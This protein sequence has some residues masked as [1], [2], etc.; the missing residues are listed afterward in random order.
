[1]SQKWTLASNTTAGD[2]LTGI[3]NA[4][5]HLSTG[6]LVQL[7]YDPS[8][9][10]PNKYSLQLVPGTAHTTPQTIATLNA[11]PIA[12]GGPTFATGQQL[13]ICRDAS[14]NLYVIGIVANSSLPNYLAGN[15]S[16]QAFTKG[17]G[18]T[19]SAQTAV[20][21]LNIPQG[22][23]TLSQYQ[24]ATGSGLN[25]VWVNTGGGTNGAGHLMVMGNSGNGFTGWLYT[26][27]AGQMLLG[28]YTTNVGSG[29]VSG[30]GSNPPPTF[31]PNCQDVVASSFGATTGL[32]IGQVGSAANNAVVTAWSVNSSGVI[33]TTVITASVPTGTLSASTKFSV[34]LLQSNRY[35]VVF[36]S[37]SN[38][39]QMTVINYSG[40]A[41]LSVSGVDTGTTSNFPAPSATL[42]W[43]CSVG[44]DGTLYVFGWSSATATTMLR[45]PF[46]F[47]G[48]VI[49]KGSVVTDDTAIGSG[50]TN[51]TIRLVN[52]PIDSTHVDYQTTNTNGST[53]GLLG[54]FSTLPGPTN[55]PVLL[56]P[57]NN[58]VENLNAGYM[59]TWQ[60]S[61]PAFGDAQTA[62]AFKRQASGGTVQW[63]TGAAWTTAETFISSV[64]SSVTFAAA[65]WTAATTYTWAVAT[66]GSA[67]IAGPYAGWWTIYS[68]NAAPST[69]TISASYDTS[70]NRVTLTI[71]G[72]GTDVAEVQVSRDGGVTWA[73]LRNY[74]ALALAAGAGTAYDYEAV[75][76]SV[77]TYRVRQYN[78]SQAPYDT[79]SAWSTSAT[80]TPALTPNFWLRN[81]ADGSIGMAVK[82]KEGT[83][84]TQLTENLT[85][86]Y[87]L[88]SSYPVVLADT[89]KGEDGQATM[90]TQGTTEETNLKALMSQQN[91]LLLQS[92]D[93]RQWYIR[94]SVSRARNIPQGTGPNPYKEWAVSWV[95]V[96]TP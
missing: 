83:F 78:T 18:L 50:G 29:N 14:D 52:Q 60:F 85:V 45:L 42:S 91:T 2:R 54:D 41:K 5:L 36:P 89:L 58:D 11:G 81:P 74:S 94:F 95:Q 4:S 55:A 92:P 67:A 28:S 27:D 32:L 69:P 23:G 76:G 87:P 43:D 82:V 8:Q 70:N 22:G 9:A 13:T 10:D 53:V 57:V 86:H 66:K 3:Q 71:T 24:N 51:S 21:T 20:N 64:T 33:T 30:P 38:A 35:A 63:W 48:D 47:P 17:A 26:F 56:T 12:A 90:F 65:N 7:V 1:M 75:P 6:D 40:T 61:S 96:A 73:D 62:Y 19:W 88:G 77:A 44:P 84:Q 93:N 68:G 79:A 25:A 15:L 49:T 34:I 31:Y 59:F 72:T 37:S 46:T 16:F 39:G 80:A